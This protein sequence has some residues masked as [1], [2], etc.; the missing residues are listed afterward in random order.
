MSSEES[1]FVSMVTFISSP[2]HFGRKKEFIIFTVTFVLNDINLFKEIFSFCIFMEIRMIFGSDS[3]QGKILPGLLEFSKEH[4]DISLVI[5]YA[6][7]DNTPDKVRRLALK[8]YGDPDMGSGNYHQ[9]EPIAFISGAGM[10]NALTGAVKGYARMDDLVIGVSIGDSV[11]QGLSAVLSTCEKP[12]RNPV[13]TVPLNGTYAAANIAKRFMEGEGRYTKVVVAMDESNVLIGLEFRNE[14]GN[15]LSHYDLPYL[16]LPSSKISAD[17]LVVT[18]FSA[19]KVDLSSLLFIDTKLQMGKGVQIAVK[20]SLPLVELE[21]EDRSDDAFAE[22]DV[23]EYLTYFKGNF[24]ATGYVTAG[25]PV[26]AMI[27]A[28]QMMRSKD[29]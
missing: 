28:A 7:A 11:T 24:K 4:P 1:S 10:S 8:W 29:V 17:D 22:Q 2:I 13:L 18:P 20:D 19:G 5:Q 6:S 12:P 27:V 9:R 21:A 15:V 23:L 3:D 25:Q 16:V 14:V 26:N